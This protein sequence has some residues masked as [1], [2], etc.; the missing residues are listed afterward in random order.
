MDVLRQWFGLDR[1]D[2]ATRLALATKS[3]TALYHLPDNAE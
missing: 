3:G 2:G 1:F